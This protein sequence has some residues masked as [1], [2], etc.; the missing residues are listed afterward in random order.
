MRPRLAMSLILIMISVSAQISEAQIIY[1]T[2]RNLSGRIVYQHWKLTAGPDGKDTTLTQIAMPISVFVPLAPHWEV[3]LDAAMSRSQLDDGRSSNSISSVG[4]STL[5]LFHSFAADRLFTA[6]GLVLPTGKTGYDTLQIAVAQLI[7]D[8]YLNVPLKQPGGG[9]GF[10]LQV[11]GAEQHDWLLFG[12]SAGFTY[13]GAY[14]YLNNGDKYNP[15]DELIAQGSA[16]AV[17]NVGSVDLDVA[18][19]YY[20]ADKVGSDKIYKNGGV[21]SAVLSGKYNFASGVA[22]VTIAEIIRSRNSLQFGTELRP[23]DRQS[24]G[25]KT[26]FAG[27]VSYS[28][29]PQWSFSLLAEYRLLS[30]N[31]FDVSSEKYFGK[32]D[33]FGFGGG[34]QYTAADGH[35]SVF[36]RFVFSS[37]EANKNALL[38]PSISITGSELSVGGRI[39]F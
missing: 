2:P 26:V 30:A 18:Y 27:N 35:Y 21:L 8:D 23:E 11:G 7:A 37:G 32:S 36:G 39:G 24:A 22:G 17:G 13:A 9:A 31:K 6:V 4:L 5:R 1:G 25:N 38:R 15:G 28:F 19:K 12:G 10:I 16:T 20:T 29:T 3:H 14:E 34:L 33:L